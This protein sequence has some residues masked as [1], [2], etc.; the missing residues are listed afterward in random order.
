MKK[1]QS[2]K[3]V[4]FLGIMEKNQILDHQD[5]WCIRGGDGDGGENPPPPPPRG[6]GDD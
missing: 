4:N 2:K 6:W 3:L 1:D 5:M